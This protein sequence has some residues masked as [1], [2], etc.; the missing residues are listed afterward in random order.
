MISHHYSPPLP[1]LPVSTLTGNQT[2]LHPLIQTLHRFP[3]APRTE[4]SVPNTAIKAVSSSNHCVLAASFC[5]V[6]TRAFLLS[7]SDEEEADE[8][9]LRRRLKRESHRWNRRN[10]HVLSMCCHKSREERPSVGEQGQETQLLQGQSK[11]RLGIH[12]ATDSFN[13][14]KLLGKTVSGRECW[15]VRQK[16]KVSEGSK[17]GRKRLE[18]EIR[19]KKCVSNVCLC[20]MS[21]IV[22]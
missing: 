14:N 13:K 18:G 22:W 16:L 21:A 19:R 1:R 4:I 10:G 9:N 11:M 3:A 7:L 2:T 6:S 17:E 20:E 5:F 8:T 12:E 15:R